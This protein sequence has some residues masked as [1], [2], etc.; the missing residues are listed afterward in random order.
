[1]QFD[2]TTSPMRHDL[3]EERAMS[4][5]THNRHS[6]NLAARMGRW[7]AAHWKTATFGWLAFVL[8][9]FALGSMVGTKQVDQNAAGPGESGRMQKILDRNF[10][11]P[12]GE[13][14][15]IQ[16]NSSQVGDPAFSAAIRDVIAGVSKVA[17]VKN[18][19]RG[20]V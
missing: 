10:K 18:V 6:Q 11:E 15:L 9:A 20:P 8:V 5:G 17:V 2:N 14:V 12:V 7:S 1:M 19:Q 13:S 4:A 16:S 3:K